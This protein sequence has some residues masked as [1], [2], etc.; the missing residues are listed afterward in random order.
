MDSVTY[1]VPSRPTVRSPSTCAFPSRGSST[2]DTWAAV[3]E[4]E[5]HQRVRPEYGLDEPSVVATGRGLAHTRLCAA[6]MA[7]P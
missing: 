4:V 2:R 3:R 7:S 6:S 5:R 1:T